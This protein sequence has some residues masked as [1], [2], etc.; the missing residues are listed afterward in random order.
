MYAYKKNE[1]V[2]KYCQNNV[3]MCFVVIYAALHYSE[4]IA[5]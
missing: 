4:I 1:T 3:L 5:L 2:F